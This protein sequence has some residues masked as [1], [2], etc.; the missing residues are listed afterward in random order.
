[1]SW[2]TDFFSSNVSNL[3][4]SVGNTIDK[5]VTSDE[6]RET[7]KIKMTEELNKLKSIQI[8]AI[9]KYDSE[10]SKRHLADMQSDSWLAKNIRP[11]S[12]AFLTVS[13]VLLAYLTIFILSVEKIALIDPWLDLLKTLLITVYAFYFGSRG[14]E[15]VNSIKS[16]AEENNPQAKG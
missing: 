14:F 10:I 13:T 6:E 7:L 16:A 11:L 15:K 3:V 1:M 9:S 5:L 4:D 2:L 12:L 8:D